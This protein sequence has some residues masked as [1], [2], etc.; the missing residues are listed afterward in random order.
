MN[1]KLTEPQRMEIFHSLVEAQ[2]RGLG[3]ERSRREIAAQY[4]V[5][6]F[7]IKQIEDEGLDHQWPPL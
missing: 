5:S 2:D 4:G 3:V 1:D 6:V 7:D